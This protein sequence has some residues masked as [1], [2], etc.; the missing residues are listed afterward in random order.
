LTRNEIKHRVEKRE[1]VI[2]EDS[3]RGGNRGVEMEWRRT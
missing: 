3:S 2:S 1:G